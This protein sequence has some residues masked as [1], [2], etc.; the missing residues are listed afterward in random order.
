MAIINGTPFNDVLNGTFFADTINGFAGNDTLNGGFGND[1]LNGG[2]GNDR[3]NGGFGA[4]T[5]NGGFGND[6]LNG[7]FG[8]DTMNGGFGNDTYVVDN[9]GDVVN[10]PNFGFISGGN[11]TVESSITYTLG[12]TVENLTLTGL[13]AIDG[14]GNANNN[15]INGNSANNV[16]SG[17]A[18]N[19]TLN[20]GF[21]ADTLNG[22]L[23]DDQLNG[24]FG[25]DTLNGGFGDDQLNGGFGNDQLNGEFG[26]DTLNGGIGA[27]TLNGGIGNDT[28]SGGLGRDILTGGGGLFARDTFDYNST[29]ESQPGFFN[30]DVITDF[31]GL[32]F[33]QGDQIDLR[34]IDANVFA[35]GN[36]AF[37]YIGSAGFT[38]AGQLRYSG[39]ILQ[40][41]TDFDA[42]PEFAIQ[43]VGNPALFVGAGPGTDILL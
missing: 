22:G 5:L 3:L 35:A 8:A 41:S 7:G 15:V 32:G 18:G 36:Q 13:A 11:D 28:L 38:A 34:D 12:A 16:L 19:D 43:L 21:G 9:V 40:G 26:N 4:D 1:T 25:A 39:G 14:T 30:R 37:T 42:A 17:L 24:G 29:D 20:G 23:G 10:D 2:L 31:Q 33:F 27:D 6:T